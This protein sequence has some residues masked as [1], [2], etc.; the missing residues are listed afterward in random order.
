MAKFSN[1]E[2]IGNEI[3]D[4]IKDVR[5]TGVETYSEVTTIADIIRDTNKKVTELENKRTGAVD[6]F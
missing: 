3:V 4:E 6:T 1:I 2:S 5:R